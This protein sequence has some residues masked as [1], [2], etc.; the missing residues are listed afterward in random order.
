MN[1]G[2]IQGS[3]KLV[4]GQARKQWGKEDAEKQIA[5]WQRKASD[6]WFKPKP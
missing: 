6:S 5:E 1:R 3:W 2:Q 4:I